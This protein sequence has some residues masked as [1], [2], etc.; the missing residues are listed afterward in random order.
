VAPARAYT[1]QGEKINIL[2]EM[3]FNGLQI[4]KDPRKIMIRMCQRH[5]YAI[6]SPEKMPE[7]RKFI[8][9]L[10][11]SRGGQQSDS[12]SSRGCVCI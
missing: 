11:Q 10:P 4:N 2:I 6:Q 1:L 12:V 7:E 5:E 3:E 8:L 9:P